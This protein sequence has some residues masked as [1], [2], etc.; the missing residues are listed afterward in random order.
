[1]NKDNIISESKKNHTHKQ[2]C[3]CINTAIQL[4]VAQTEKEI[5][6]RT[7]T[8]I[9]SVLDWWKEHEY[10]TGTTE[11]DEYNVYDEEPDFVKKAKE[12]KEMLK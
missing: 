10:D 1:M 7:E 3:G 5:F 6:Q 2:N 12:L 8:L 9:K 11:D 4:T